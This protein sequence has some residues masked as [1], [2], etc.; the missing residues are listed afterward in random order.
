MRE[1]ALARGLSTSRADLVL[2]GNELRA[3]HG[4]GVLVDRLAPRLTPPAIVDSVRNPGE[5]EALRRLQGFFLLGVNAPPE[6]RL[7]RIKTRGRLGDIRTAAEFKLYESRENS[8]DTRG[9]RISATLEMAG[10]I[11]INDASLEE[12]NGRVMAALE[13]CD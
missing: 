4:P 9:L 8:D 5:V 11:V 6:V 3:V 10:A 12:L 1:E 13:R 2:V 7:A